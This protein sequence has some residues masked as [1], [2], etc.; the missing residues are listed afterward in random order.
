VLWATSAAF[1]A[2]ADRRPNVV[3]ILT[4][5]Q[6]AWTLGCYG[7][8]DIR[9]PNIDR[10]A[11]EGMRFDRCFSCNAVCSPTRATYLTGLIPSQHGVHSY[12]GAGS[13]KGPNA[14]YTLKEF[15]TLPGIL[16]DAGYVCGLAGKWHLGD[17][18]HPQDGFTYW[19]TKPGGHT[20]TFYDAE[21]IEN[22][23]IHKE[24]TYLTDFWTH[25]AVRFIEQNKDKPFFLYLPYNG[26]Y[27]LGAWLDQPG[28]GRHVADYADKDLPC[29]PREPIHE[30]LRGNRRFVGNI[31]AMRRYSEEITGVDDGVGVIMATLTRLG[32]DDNT[33]VVFAA[34][35]GL[36][37]GHHG[38]WG[39]ADHGRPLNTFD[40]GLR[41]PLIWRFPR[42][43]PAGGHSDI[44]LSNYDFMPTILNYLGLADREAKLPES[45]G[46]DYSAVL[47]G[48]TKDWDNIV[49]YEYEN[50][51]MVRTDRWK[52]TRRFP[53]GPDELYDLTRDPGE[54]RNLFGNPEQADVQRELQQ[55][56]DA[57][58]KRYADPKYDLWRG[59]ISKAPLVTGRGT[60]RPASSPAQPKRVQP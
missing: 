13:I 52:L 10:L 1:A 47:R 60:T 26:P 27:G 57:F 28:R 54:R 55:R 37:A 45:P 12:L 5:N 24:P 40:A 11:A 22:E 9:T 8:K 31:N 6:S 36:S 23:A 32:L 46:R 2:E 29:F 15:R 50:S 25:H 21:V 20:N 35:Q 33:L 4:D 19:V 48:Q 42:R 43:I 53:E 58:F 34:D 17:C 3:F 56:L 44:L 41:I 30:W 49:F 18:L 14:Y 51:R 16:H 59:G 38:F 39:M 7:N